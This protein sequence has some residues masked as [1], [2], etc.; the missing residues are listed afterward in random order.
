MNSVNLDILVKNTSGKEKKKKRTKIR[1]IFYKFQITYF[2][3][4]IFIKNIFL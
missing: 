2:Y 1:L 3:K 4:F